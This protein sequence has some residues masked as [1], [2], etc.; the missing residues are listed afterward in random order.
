MT[1]S[2]ESVREA[3]EEAGRANKKFISFSCLEENSASK[4][5]VKEVESWQ[6]KLGIP[7]R[8]KIQVPNSTKRVD[9]PQEGWFILYELSLLLGMRF[10]LTK[11]AAKVLQ[12][13]GI[14]IG[15]LMSNTWRVL[16][17]ISVLGAQAEIEPSVVD[18]RCLYL[19]K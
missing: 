15:Q 9:S 11:L 17:G 13:Y 4:L 7:D 18:L 16:Y 1:L 19:L 2:E 5:K 6:E 12:Y 10:P 14:M 3:E 8:I